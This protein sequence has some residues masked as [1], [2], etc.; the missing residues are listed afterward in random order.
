MFH[1]NLNLVSISLLLNILS[2]SIVGGDDFLL[3]FAE[4]KNYLAC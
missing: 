3:N 2:A 4:N 1:K